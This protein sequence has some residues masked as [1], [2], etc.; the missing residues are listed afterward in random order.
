MCVQLN[1]DHHVKST[2]AS[3][4]FGLRL[5]CRAVF[6]F[7]VQVVLALSV[8]QQLSVE[9]RQQE[10]DTPALQAQLGLH[11]HDGA[12]VVARLWTRNDADLITGEDSDRK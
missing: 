7:S 11:Q 8:E 4:L 10:L 6:T 1:P 9:G 2:L 3:S 5:V 12:A